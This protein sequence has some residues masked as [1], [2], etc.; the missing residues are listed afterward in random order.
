MSLPKPASVTR[1]REQHQHERQL[2]VTSAPCHHRLLRRYL[3]R[4][5]SASI[6]STRPA[7]GWEQTEDQAGDH[8]KSDR[9]S[10]RACVKVRRG[11]AENSIWRER[12]DHRATLRA[13]NIPAVHRLPP[14]QTSQR[15]RRE[16]AARRPTRYQRQFPPRRSAHEQIHHV[17]ACT[18]ATRPTAANNIVRARRRSTLGRASHK[19]SV[20]MLSVWRMSA[21]ARNSL[22]RA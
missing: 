6:A 12:R 8:C 20:V 5:L 19:S 16:P 3:A 15:T 4:C 13:R 1:S 14:A 17:D 10:Q 18:S 22:V 2:R 21:L 9:E 11:V 7:R